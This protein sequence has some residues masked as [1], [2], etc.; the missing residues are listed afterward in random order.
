MIVAYIRNV[1]FR[2]LALPAPVPYPSPMEPARSVYLIAI[3]LALA[4]LTACAPGGD[5]TDAPAPTPTESALSDI[6]SIGEL[7][8]TP[9]AEAGPQ[10]L[11]TLDPQLVTLGED[12]YQTYCA[13]CHGAELEGQEDWKLPNPDG[14]FRAP[15]HDGTGHTWHHSDRVLR[16]A[17]LLGGERL[18][19]LGTSNMP[20]YQGVLS[21][22]EVEAVI[23]Y[24][25]STWP[26]EI[27]RLQRD[28]TARDPGPGPLDD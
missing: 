24:I 22:R 4:T 5:A 8:G 9:A 6:P 26:E 25:K 15:P 3:L 23:A 10:A 2:A 14:S 11:P 7:A 28:V 17:I 1:R 27:R 12:V 20:A 16:E 18:G 21:E 13:A 19:A